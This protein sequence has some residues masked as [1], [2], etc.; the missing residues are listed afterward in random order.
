MTRRQHSPAATDALHFIKM[1][2]NPA[3]ANDVAAEEVEYEKNEGD[4]SDALVHQADPQEEILEND[5]DTLPSDWIEAVDETSGQTY[6]YNTVTQETS[7]EKPSPDTPAEDPV[8]GNGGIQD[9]MVDESGADVNADEPATKTVEAETI[10]P[11]DELPSDWVE[12]VDEATGQEN[13]LNTATQETSWEKPSISFSDTG[14]AIVNNEHEVAVDE[15]IGNDSDEASETESVRE[16]EKQEDYALPREWIEA[17]D[18]S[19]GQTYYYN[20][21]TQETSWE[22]PKIEGDESALEED[23][24]E[25]ADEEPVSEQRMGDGAVDVDNTDGVIGNSLD[26]SQDSLPKGWVE[27]VDEDSGNVY[28]YN[29]ETSETSWEKPS[30]ISSEPRSSAHNE[31]DQDDKPE[32]VPN[33]EWEIVD[34]PKD[35][36]VVEDDTK[37]MDVD[38][39]TH[40]TNLCDERFDFGILG[41]LSLSDDE[42]VLAYIKSKSENTR[43]PLWGL[44]DIAARSRGR[45]RSED[46]VA[47]RSSPESSIVKLL[48]REENGSTPAITPSKQLPSSTPVEDDDDL[49]MERVQNLLLRGNR[50][51]AVKEAVERKDFATALLVASMCDPETYKFAAKS[52][53]EN[54]FAGGSPMYTIG[55]L[56]SGSMQVPTES[57]S[58][59]FWGI[60]ANELNGTW[61]KHLAAV[62]SNRTAGWDRVVLS[63]GDRLREIGAVEGAH[64]CYMICGC[65]FTDPLDATTR[66]SLLGDDHADTSIISLTTNAA[67]DSFDRTEAYEWA[68]RRGN[69]N[70]TIK[71]FQ[72]FKVI[73]ATTLVDFGFEEQATLFALG[74]RHCAD[75]TPAKAIDLTGEQWC[76]VFEDPEALAGAFRALEERLDLSLDEDEDDS[77]YEKVEGEEQPASEG[78]APVVMNANDSYAEENLDPINSTLNITDNDATFVTAA[79]NLMDKPGFQMTPQREA[80]QTLTAEKKKLA[81]EPTPLQEPDSIEPPKA[82]RMP[83]MPPPVAPLKEDD[84]KI[85]M[86]GMPSRMPPTPTM[87]NSESN[88]EA[89]STP[90]AAGPPAAAPA[91]TPKETI[92]QPHKAPST[93]PSVMMGKKNEPKSDKKKA[94]PSS[95]EKPRSGGLLSGFRSMMIKRFNK[96]AVECTLPDNEEKAYY[97]EKLKRWV[98]PGDDLDELAKPMAPPP[99]MPGGGDSTPA[100][101]PEPKADVSNDPLAAMMAPPSRRPVRRPGGTPTMPPVG[102]AMPPMAGMPPMMPGMPSPVAGGA[103]AAPPQFAVFTPAKKEEDPKKNEE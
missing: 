51:E 77:E 40:V 61:K 49:R 93:A 9:S 102:G 44:I 60:G 43:S 6:Y 42:A 67:I 88:K 66:V 29:S 101:E 10:D 30:M 41:P 19:S 8:D 13:Y 83:T 87:R 7:W 23:K 81:T 39:S 75:V 2:D 89:T 85:D 97:D 22:K 25:V 69:K 21:V 17:V 92:K 5:N 18:E 16:K 11:E 1:I 99:I 63:L 103:P 82:E 96:D 38:L 78:G 50:V 72:P 36:V 28:Y 70:A 76:R 52:Y 100:A 32:V 68:K 14:E 56:F 59:S 94:A 71:S 20:T 79:S 98:F 57:S 37:N 3:D 46:G 65:R 64:F 86:N 12:T 58:G 34:E 80:P 74:I 90:M 27:V 4:E 48:L 33:E 84:S 45:L 54:V 55:M 35:D 26:V 73:F 31:L 95:T 53:A 15:M 24:S 91:M 47:D 62:I